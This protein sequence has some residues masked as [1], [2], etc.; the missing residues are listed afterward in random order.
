VVRSRG[1]SAN[2]AAAVARIVRELNPGQPAPG[3]VAM[4]DAVAA[5]VAIPRFAVRILGAFAVT[6]V[7]LASLGLYGLVAGS[8]GRRTREIGMRVILGA[9]PM[10]IVRLVLAEG[11]RP[12]AA[13]LA[14]GVATGLAA[15]RVAASLLYGVAPNDPVTIVSACCVLLFVAVCASAIPTWRALRLQPAQTLREL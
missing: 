14:L 15:G 9:R 10:T 6:A 5:A 12:A 3:V 13:G 2:T 8:V 7:L 1:D 4:K 11:L